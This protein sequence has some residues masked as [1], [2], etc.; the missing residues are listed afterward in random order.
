MYG[1]VAAL[2]V[3]LMLLSMHRLTPQNLWLGTAMRVISSALVHRS[4]TREESRIEYKVCEESRGWGGRIRTFDWLIQVLP[5]LD[6]F[7]EELPLEA[8]TGACFPSPPGAA[9]VCR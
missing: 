2:V 4:C 9:P 7:L 6:Q 3:K 1:H 8:G 5:P